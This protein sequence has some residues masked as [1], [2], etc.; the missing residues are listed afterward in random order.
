MRLEDAYLGVKVDTSML[1]SELMGRSFPDTTIS[2]QKR[3]S[4][5]STQ[6]AAWS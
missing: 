5:P 3:Q 4:A 1:N 6:T 2:S